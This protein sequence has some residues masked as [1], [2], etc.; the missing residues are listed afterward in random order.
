M[1]PARS[2]KRTRTALTG[3]H[4]MADRSLFTYVSPGFNW[5]ADEARPI[6]N[7]S[8]S[9]G[10]RR[11]SHSRRM[12]TLRVS[13]ILV[14]A[15]CCSSLASAQSASGQTDSKPADAN[16][17][18]AILRALDQVVEQNRQLE[19]QNRE[20]MDQ[21]Q[22]MRQ[23][24]AKQAPMAGTEAT[25]KPEA[26]AAADSSKPNQQSRTPADTAVAEPP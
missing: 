2:L 25:P 23:V 9:R 7:R 4:V 1:I 26:P 8:R 13:F 16:S 15:I 14:A 22:S 19:K 24:L 5:A 6:Q 10:T 12:S 11:M 18:A 3:S 17:P 20:L 21:I